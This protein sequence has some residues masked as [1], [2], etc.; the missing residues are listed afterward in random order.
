MVLPPRITPRLTRGDLAATIAAPNVGKTTLTFL[1]A[2]AI[3]YEP[4]LKPL[5]GQAKIDWCGPVVIVS[6]ED[7]PTD[8]SARWREQRK[9]LKLPARAKHEMFIWPERLTLARFQDNTPIPTEAG[10][11]FVEKLAARAERGVRYAYIVFDPFSGLFP[12]I[13]ENNP[14]EMGDAA[15][16]CK[17]IAAA[18]FAVVEIVHH[19]KKDARNDEKIDA[20][21][22][23]SGFEGVVD[24]MSTLVMLPVKDVVELGLPASKTGRVLRLMAQRKRRGAWAGTYY[25]ERAIL[26]VPAI[27]SRRPNEMATEMGT[28]AILV[29]IPPPVK[30]GVDLD[31]AQ[32][33]LWDEHQTSGAKGKLT[34]GG[35]G[36]G[37]LGTAVM[38]VMEKCNCDRPAAEK[39]IDE[40]KDPKRVKIEAK[41]PG[42][43]SS[44]RR[45]VVTPEPPE[46]QRFRPAPGLRAISRISR[47]F[48]KNESPRDLSR[49]GR[50]S[51]V[52]SAVQAGSSGVFG[53]RFIQLPYPRPQ[54][55]YARLGTR[56]GGKEVM[57]E[58]SKAG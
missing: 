54:A 35:K 36:S 55:G 22:G 16:L 12:G 52:R 48:R 20:Y 11:E 51:G 49:Q 14:T 37:H 32:R 4:I 2:F 21:R 30:K 28:V 24:E 42:G 29:S 7:A 53:P 56:S 46:P 26:T 44:S 10:C 57:L 34:R 8:G 43:K 25:F 9:H 39:A 1:L 13:T 27:D 38:V 31:A 58:A 50:R 3:A 23:G 19:T 15:Y 41:Y 33:A 17:R 45:L 5:I 18:A 40:L 6:N 47:F